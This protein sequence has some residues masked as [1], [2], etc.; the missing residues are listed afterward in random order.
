M[1]SVVMY[2]IWLCD[3]RMRKLIQSWLFVFIWAVV[4]YDIWCCQ[5]LEPSGEL[6][7]LAKLIM[8]QGG[9]WLLVSLKVF[10]TF[11]AVELLRRVSFWYTVG[12]AV[13]EAALLAF[14]LT[15]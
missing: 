15:Y 12:V 9:V 11:L 7:P 4:A 5:Y 10:G 13:G 8:L 14:L 6:N 1:W 3:S 2:D